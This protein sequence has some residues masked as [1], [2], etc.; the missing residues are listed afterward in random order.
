MRR[1]IT[2]AFSGSV[3]KQIDRI[4]DLRLADFQKIGLLGK[5]LAQQAIVVFIKPTLP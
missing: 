5:V 3:I 4:I 2:Q 1:E